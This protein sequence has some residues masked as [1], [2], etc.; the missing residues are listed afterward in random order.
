MNIKILILVFLCFVCLWPIPSDADEV[1]PGNAGV[2]SGIFWTINMNPVSVRTAGAGSSSII[3]GGGSSRNRD[4][5]NNPASIAFPPLE[6]GVD[7]I[8]SK[9]FEGLYFNGVMGSF[10]SDF[11]LAGSCIGVSFRRFATED[12]ILDS[13]GFGID[14]FGYE[15]ISFGMV[16]GF[17]FLRKKYAGVGVKYLGEKIYTLSGSGVAFDWGVAGD[18][19]SDIYA[20]LSCLNFPGFI[21]Y[22]SNWEYTGYLKSNLK[23]SVSYIPSFSSRINP[24]FFADVNNYFVSSSGMVFEHEL[25]VGAE[26]EPYDFMVIGAGIKGNPLIYRDLASL[27]FSFGIGFSLKDKYRLNYAAEILPLGDVHHLSVSLLWF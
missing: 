8:I 15:D 11:I 2:S 17:N 19:G 13:R 7:F 20:G 24:R 26:I 18:L 25:A 10:P 27:N 3:S 4:F 9:W 6:R 23:L 21:K 5:E 14:K 22:N 12:Y 16:F 1:V